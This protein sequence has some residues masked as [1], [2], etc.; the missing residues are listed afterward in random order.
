MFW[1]IA[2]YSTSPALGRTAQGDESHVRFR[3]TEG[4]A[5][6]KWWIKG[7]CSERQGTEGLAILQ[8]AGGGAERT[9]KERQTA[10]PKDSKKFRTGR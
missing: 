5:A 4:G 3:T 2:W 10:L 6:Q 7:G 8:R 1:Y 9:S